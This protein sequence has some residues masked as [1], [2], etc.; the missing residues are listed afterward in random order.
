M[1]RLTGAV[2]RAGRQATLSAWAS[3]WGLRHAGK[4]GP[5]VTQRRQHRPGAQPKMMPPS[6][7][8]PGGVG[9]LHW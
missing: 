3:I 2:T 7:D 4:P 9:G 8:K 6:L 5:P 1:Q